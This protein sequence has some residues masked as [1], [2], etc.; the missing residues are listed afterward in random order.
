MRTLDEIAAHFA[1]LQASAAASAETWRLLRLSE[2]RRNHIRRVLEACNGNRVRAAR[3]LGIG[4][5]SLC[6]FPKSSDQHSAASIG[7]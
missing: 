3:P 7:A 5:T 6:G 2:M 4:R 1:K